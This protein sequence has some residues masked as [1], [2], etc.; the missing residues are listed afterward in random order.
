[1]ADM[2][3]PEDHAARIIRADGP[4]DYTRRR[5]PR[6]SVDLLPLSD[7]DLAELQRSVADEIER[8]AKVGMAP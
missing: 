6:R 5:F 2:T 3:I 7:T 8:R 4:A 1:M